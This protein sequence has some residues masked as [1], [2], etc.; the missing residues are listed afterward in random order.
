MDLPN[1]VELLDAL[2]LLGLLV[3][4]Y[5]LRGYAVHPPTTPLICAVHRSTVA[6]IIFSF[7]VRAF[8]TD[9]FVVMLSSR[10][11]G[12]DNRI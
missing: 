2:A 3:R 11:K 7:V 6:V 1:G 12:M 5:S 4:F 9:L 10:Q 8:P